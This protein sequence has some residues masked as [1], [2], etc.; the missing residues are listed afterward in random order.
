MDSN[1]PAK[2]EQQ[3]ELFDESALPI[4]HELLTIEKDEK[5]GRFTGEIV[6][7]NRER[8][9]AI[10][11]A[12]AEGFGIRQIARAFHVSCNTIFAIRDREGHAIETE[13]KQLAGL[14]GRFV[15]MSVERLIEEHDQIPVGQLPVALGIVQD[16]RALL[17]GDPTVRVD[18][19]IEVAIS[20]SDLAGMLERMKRAQVIDVSPA[21]LPEPT[22]DSQSEGSPQT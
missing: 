13:K 20:A 12:L 1:L 16:K 7:R 6:A 3:P 21:A 2:T 18:E 22:S 4:G 19:R 8:Y 9:A 14:M 15:R 5:R 10:V 17:E 11:R